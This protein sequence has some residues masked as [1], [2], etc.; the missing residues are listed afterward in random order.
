MILN[1]Q[2]LQ[3]ELEKLPG[4]ELSMITDTSIE[5]TF[6]L[7]SFEKAIMFVNEIAKQIEKPN[8]KIAIDENMV[9]IT[10]TTPGQGVTT[11]NIKQARQIEDIYKAMQ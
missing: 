5:K 10:I 2:Q 4:W 7:E 8:P 3:Q 9:K 11:Q 1:L 6:K